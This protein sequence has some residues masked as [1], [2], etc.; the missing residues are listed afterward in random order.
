M[1]KK[2][3]LQKEIDRLKKQLDNMKEENNL[4][5]YYIGRCKEEPLYMGDTDYITNIRDNNG[6][7]LK[8][9][10]V[11]RLWGFQGEDNG[12][13]SVCYDEET[14]STFVPGIKD[15]PA[16]AREK[17]FILEKIKDASDV[18]KGYRTDGIVYAYSEE[19]AKA[20]KK[21]EKEF[22]SKVFKECIEDKMPE[23]L[24]TLLETLEK[25]MED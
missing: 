23:F 24:K 19:Q 9:G 17:L 16:E 13:K 20:I 21:K 2:E 6:N 7:C 12:T 1:S 15:L 11:I 8:T 4:K 18:K 3:D 5:M 22:S 10:D 14:N 25:H